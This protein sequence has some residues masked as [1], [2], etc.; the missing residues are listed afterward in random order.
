MWGVGAAQAKIGVKMILHKDESHLDF[1]LF[2]IVCYNNDTNFKG[3]LKSCTIHVW[4][5]RPPL[6]EIS[7]CTICVENSDLNITGKN[8]SC[9][10]FNL[11]AATKMKMNFWVFI[12]SVKA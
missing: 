1:M 9:K 5:L 4:D 12:L 3:I 2:V 10:S 6:V 7:S 8:K 11:K